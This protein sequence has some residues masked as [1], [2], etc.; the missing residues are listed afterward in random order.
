[1][2][3]PEWCRKKMFAALSLFVCGLVGNLTITPDAGF[4]ALSS[5]SGEVLECREWHGEVHSHDGCVDL[6]LML[7]AWWRGFGARRTSVLHP[8]YANFRTRERKWIGFQKRFAAAM[9][10]RL[11]Y[12]GYLRLSDQHTLHFLAACKRGQ[13]GLK[14]REMETFGKKVL[15]LRC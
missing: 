12:A 11:A 8:A 3:L 7:E 1:M 4:L 9:Q 10:S 14:Y 2:L 6:V 13:A 5:E 15:L